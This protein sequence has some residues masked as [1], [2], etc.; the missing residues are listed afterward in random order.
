MNKK[1]ILEPC[2]NINGIDFGTDREEVRKILAIEFTEFKKSKY[3]KN[4]TDDYGYFHVFYDIHNQMEAIEIF[5]NIDLFV[6]EKK[7]FPSKVDDVKDIF[8]DA[9]IE[10]DELTSVNY[11]IGA[12]LQDG[13]LVTILVG[14]KDYYV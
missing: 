10:N 6:N 8:N 5:D 9:I 13:N 11:S 14:C 7:L 12:T 3:S 4:T 2:K 1:W